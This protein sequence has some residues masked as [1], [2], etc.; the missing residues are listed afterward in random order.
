MNIRQYLTVFLLGALLT[1][2]S[3]LVVLFNVD[4]LEAG[5]FGLLLFHFTFFLA[6]TSTSITV[7]TSLRVWFSSEEDVPRAMNNS[8]RQSI[9]FSLL[10][11][12]LLLFSGLQLLHWWIFLLLFVVVGV[13]EYFFLETKQGD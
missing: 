11:T 6:L 8:L 2:G 13:I 7:V 12:L 10:I 4:P 3:F 1:A 5:F 9:L